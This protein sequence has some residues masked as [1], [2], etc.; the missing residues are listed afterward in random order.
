MN[1]LKFTFTRW[2]GLECGASGAKLA[3][4]NKRNALIQV[5][6][7]FIEDYPFELRL[8]G[9]SR[10]P[11]ELVRRLLTH[12][13]LNRYQTVFTADE[14]AVKSCFAILPK[15]NKS[16]MDSAI[17][18]QAKKLLLWEGPEPLMV[19]ISSEFLG[20]HIGALIGLADWNAVNPW[21][22]LIENSGGV[23][24]NLTLTACAYQA[25]AQHQGW[26]NS[27]AIIMVADLGAE[28]SSFYVLDRQ[29]VRFM[30]KV[31]VGGDAVTRMLS[32]EVSTEAGPIQLSEIE[33][34]EVKTTGR[35]PET[36]KKG[37]VLRP[38]IDGED[39][40]NQPPPVTWETKLVEH[41]DMLA[42]PM[43][44][45][46]TSELARSI[47]FYKDN[48]GQ[49]VEAVYLTGGTAGLKLLQKHL[50]TS[51]AL[52]VKVIDPFAGLSIT[53][54]AVAHFAE[55]N[56]LRLAVAVGLALAGE[57]ALSLLPHHMKI[58]KRFVAFI[59]SV[60][61]ALLLAA[62]LPFMV[63]GACQMIK[64][65]AARKANQ[66]YQIQVQRINAERQRM[67]NLQQQL[68]EASERHRA[69]QQ[70]LGR[71]PLWPGVFN[72]LAEATPPYIVLT[73]FNADS[74]PAQPNTIILEGNVL[75]SAAGFDNAMAKFLYALS[76]SPFFRY[77]SIV[78][79][80][81]KRTE[82]TLGSFKIQCE[83]I[84]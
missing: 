2:A 32:T 15:I 76:T 4:L 56:R 9:K 22:R 16:E 12:K 52:P 79:A 77:V 65:Q 11:L 24:N 63:G 41:L 75:P 70:L 5:D 72:M 33:A 30:R 39:H 29:N 47:Q 55:K 49:K 27:A 14:S 19:Y 81:A 34:E 66:Q 38:I 40:A 73:R 20:N 61:A 25:L 23:I 82:T 28:F 8:K 58:L 7:L 64:I 17:L 53:N 60:I 48:S 69:L 54:T 59:P 50:E 51:L 44:E 42:R 6:H 13:N 67:Q 62:F 21:C 35:L 74:A 68:E 83:L 31:P 57:T 84:F 78:Q 71:T 45:R 46:L 37:A 18:L 10:P 3:L 1:K 26:T 36:V 80:G 43:I